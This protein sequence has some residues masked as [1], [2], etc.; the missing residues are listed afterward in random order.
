MGGGDDDKSSNW[1]FDI[2]DEE[3]TTWSDRV[4]SIEEASLTRLA[5]EM[6]ADKDERT[7]SS[8]EISAVVRSSWS[9]SSSS[10]VDERLLSKFDFR[11][12]DEFVQ[13]VGRLDQMQTVTQTIDGLTA[14][15]SRY[16]SIIPKEEKCSAHPSQTLNDPTRQFDA[17]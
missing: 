11:R 5:A 17:S 12:P 9:S 14:Q 8:A 4:W 13:H 1:S 16:L 3:S 7:V 15:H 6:I 10:V 2:E